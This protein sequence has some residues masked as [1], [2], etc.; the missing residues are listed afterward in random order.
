MCR[1]QELSQRH[2]WSQAGTHPTKPPQ[3]GPE[4]CPLLPVISGWSD[5]QGCA[6]HGQGHV[7]LFLVWTASWVEGGVGDSAWSHRCERR[8]VLV[9]LVSRWGPPA[10]ASHCSLWPCF[11]LCQKSHFYRKS[12]RPALANDAHDGQLWYFIAGGLISTRP[13]FFFFYFCEREIQTLIK[14]NY[15]LKIIQLTI[16]E[17]LER[18]TTSRLPLDPL[19]QW[20]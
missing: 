12:T 5:V 17:E 10:A 16:W 3:P 11:F 6:S 20:T 19:V 9:H 18:E 1:D 14:W 7:L 8:V 15:L 13:S 4:P 2:F